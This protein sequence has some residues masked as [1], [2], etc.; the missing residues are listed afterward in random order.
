[1]A[2]EAGARALRVLSLVM[3]VF[4][5]FMGI[6]KIG[7]VTDDSFLTGRLYQWLEVARPVNRWYLEQVAL[8]GAAVFARLV[9]LGELATGT[10]LL[11]GFQ[12]RIA[13]IVALFMVL[14]FHFAS[15]V[16]LQYSY[17]INGYGPPVL[18]GLLALAI[19][20]A[21]LPWTVRTRS[22]SVRT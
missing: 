3:G 13:A 1:M 20:G 22:S 11:L 6:D 9:P 5:L 2:T 18:G 8:P 14:N 7:W 4:L 19:G 21:T 10:A 12:V 17:L 15:D 16:L